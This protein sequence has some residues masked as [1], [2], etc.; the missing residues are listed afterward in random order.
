LNVAESFEELTISKKSDKTL[1]SFFNPDI[2]PVERTPSSADLH[3]D[4]LKLLSVGM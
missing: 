2:N 3:T 1:N 4:K